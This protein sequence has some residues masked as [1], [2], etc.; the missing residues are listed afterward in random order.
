M[1]RDELA[2]ASPMKL[3]RLSGNRDS[4]KAGVCFVEKN[5]SNDKHFARRKSLDYLN[6]NLINKSKELIT[7]KFSPQHR[8]PARLDFLGAMSALR[9]P[10]E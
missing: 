8:T 1:T 5:S 4:F 9:S 3:K 7:M 10:H 2:Q 6:L